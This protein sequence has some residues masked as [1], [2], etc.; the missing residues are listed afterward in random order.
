MVAT[1]VSL[2]TYFRS[3]DNRRRKTQI[4]HEDSEVWHGAHNLLESRTEYDLTDKEGLYKS[5]TVYKQHHVMGAR[6]KSQ[7]GGV[8]SW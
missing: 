3:F 7:Y 2:S 4:R 5:T 8:H 6:L 1:L